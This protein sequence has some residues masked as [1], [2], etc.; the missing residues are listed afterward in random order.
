MSLEIKD[1]EHLANLSRISLSEEEKQAFLKDFTAILGYV[2]ELTS[3]TNSAPEI[4]HS[5]TNVARADEAMY[6][7][8]THT[9][10]VLGVA[11]KRNGEYV[12]VDQ[13]F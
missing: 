2:S 8:H 11:P 13:V 6:D 10:T 4:V 12:Q 5:P 1:I 3:V 9:E 7:P